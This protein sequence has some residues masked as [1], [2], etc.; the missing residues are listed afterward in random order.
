[1]TSPTVTTTD[2]LD[3][4]DRAAVQEPSGAFASVANSGLSSTIGTDTTVGELDTNAAAVLR[5]RGK[6][7]G[8]LFS[9]QQPVLSN[10]ASFGSWQRQT[11][12]FSPFPTLP[13]PSQSTA[14]VYLAPDTTRTL[15]PGAYG[16]VTLQPRSRL[17]ISAGDYAFTSFDFESTAHLVVDTSHGPVRI[18]TG[19]V[20]LFR[21][22][23]DMTVA[24][25]NLFTFGYTGT[26]PLFVES[27]FE[28][29]LVAPS[30]EVT[31]RAINQAV[32]S[33]QFFARTLHVDAGAKVV[34]R[35]LGCE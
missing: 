16:V 7:T 3:I 34:H 29:T 14:V 18:T 9:P 2:T 6:I 25:A 4:R 11:P 23:F 30:S 32:H 15:T 27:A 35:V 10:G 33:G 20:T 17:L 12:P 8:L 26:A 28:G 24:Q 22:T 19:A 5:D 1:V 13:T 31:L 21:G